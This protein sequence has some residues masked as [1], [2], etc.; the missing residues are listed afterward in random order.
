MVFILYCLTLTRCSLSLLCSYLCCPPYLIINIIFCDY[1]LWNTFQYRVWLSSFFS[2]MEEVNM[3]LRLLGSLGRFLVLACVVAVTTPAMAGNCSTGKT[4]YAQP[5]QSCNSECSE[6]CTSCGNTECG[7]CQIVEKTVR[8][9]QW[10]TETKLVSCNNSCGSHYK[11]CGRRHH[12][13]SRRC[14]R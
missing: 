13:R 6:G 2:R 5:C 9:P 8:R 11:T 4:S 3:K 7:Q 10:V 14:R 1:R 12:K